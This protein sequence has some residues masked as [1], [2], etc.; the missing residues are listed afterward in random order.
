[1][2]ARRSRIDFPLRMV[3]LMSVIRLL[4]DFLYDPLAARLLLGDRPA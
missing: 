1:M 2:A 3:G 4:P